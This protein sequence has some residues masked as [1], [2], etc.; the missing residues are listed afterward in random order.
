MVET[1]KARP[2][3][4]TPERV[5][6]ETTSRKAF[7]FLLLSLPRHQVTVNLKYL[8]FC[9]AEGRMQFHFVT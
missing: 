6:M 2:G 8:T 7:L 9:I 4:D 1:K 3:A 5:M